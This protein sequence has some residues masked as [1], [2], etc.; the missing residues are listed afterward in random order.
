M[1]ECDAHFCFL[2]ISCLK[3][4]DV[5]K[6]LGFIEEGEGNIDQVCAAECFNIRQRM[7]PI[8]KGAMQ[9]AIFGFL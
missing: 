7:L 9:P 8:N 4:W 1:H 5:T 6:D 2:S 3:S